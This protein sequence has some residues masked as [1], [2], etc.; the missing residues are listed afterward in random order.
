MF[1]SFFPRPTLFFGSAFIWS[2]FCAILWYTVGEG[3]GADFSLGT[4][5]GIDFPGVLE[6]GSDEAATA[7]HAASQKTA[8]NFWL[9]QYVG[10]GYLLFVIAWLIFSPHPW[11]RW[12][13]V[14][15]AIIMFV[16]WFLVR[17]DVLI[18]EWFGSF[19]NLIQNALADPNSV[20]LGEFYGQ[21]II[22]GKLAAIWITIR[23]LN[24]FFVS[25]Y[26]FRWRTAMNN[27][28]TSKWKQVRHI[29]GASQRVQ[30]D[31]MA[32]ARIME[33]LGVAFIDS[34]MTLLA[35]LPILWG[36][37]VHVKEIPILGEVPYALVW[38]AII[39][40]IF[41]TGLLALV[42]MKLPGLEFRNQRVEAA[43]RKELVLGEDNEDRA[44]PPTLEEL[45]T[46]VRKNYFRLYFNYFYFNIFR[47]CYIQAG[48]LVPYLALAPTIVTAGFTLGVM[49]QI[50]RAF[51]RVE[52]SFQFL[53][54]SWTTIVE[55]MSIYKRLAAFEATFDG[56][57]LPK[58]DQDYQRGM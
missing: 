51:S 19:Y 41:G 2:L 21:W 7:L 25:H 29:E 44:Q 33:G 37:S 49:Q 40:S 18:N 3:W 1:K 36:L 47:Y 39:W 8:S 45:F 10:I 13:V 14:G 43:Y 6:E 20:T 28:Y 4:I 26:I 17:I 24:N 27:Y 11:S 46:N 23:V 30:E 50:L 34:I 56:R 9:Y 58:I 48:V 31:T 52:G 35:F 16:V 54:N 55:L 53:V 32:F 5:F 15:S 57:E 38:I 22:F 12:S 42:G